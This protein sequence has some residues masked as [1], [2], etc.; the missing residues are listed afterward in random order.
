M[1]AIIVSKQDIAGLNIKENL[2]QNFGFK[3]TDEINDGFPVFESGNIKLFTFREDTIYL[4]NL[5]IN[6]EY[7]IFATKHKSAS[8]MKALTV[9]SPGNWYLNELGGFKRKLCIANPDFIKLAFKHLNE[10]NILNFEVSMEA[11]HHGP[12]IDK[13]PCSFIEIGSSEDEWII[14]EAGRIVAEAI[15]R[16]VKEWRTS[17]SKVAVGIGGG[18]YTPYF[19]RISLNTDYAF[20]HIIP[21]YALP[22]VDEEMILEAMERSSPKADFVI[23]DEKGMGKDK[24]RIIEILN[25]LKIPYKKAR[26]I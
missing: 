2:I 9:H 24:Q 3:E 25:K 23:I 18:H 12:Y 20:G 16:T 17:K 13:T 10:L 19:N 21:K 15:M 4:N 11:T 6:A 7:I 22:Y 8:G 26:K 5:N 1:I 14:P